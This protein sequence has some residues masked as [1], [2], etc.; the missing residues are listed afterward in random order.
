MSKRKDPFEDIENDLKD[1]AMFQQECCLHWIRVCED[2][3]EQFDSVAEE[4]EALHQDSYDLDIN[5]EQKELDLEKKREIISNQIQQHLQ[6]SEMERIQLGK[7]N[8]ELQDHS[9]IK[10]IIQDKRKKKP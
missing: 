6:R 8:K 7:I 5:R 4:M 10:A 3:I 1:R 2:L 9:L